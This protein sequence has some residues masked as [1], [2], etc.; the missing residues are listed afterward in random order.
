MKPSAKPLKTEELRR[1]NF[2]G[3]ATPLHV[4]VGSD[5]AR[6]AT[7]ML[8]C[9]ISSGEFPSGS[10]VQMESGMV[11]SSPELCFLQ[12]AGELSLA[13]LVALGYELCGGY[14]LDMENADGFRKDLPLTSI[15]S[16]SAYVAKAA[17]L[18]GRTNALKA[19]RFI[20]D[21][22]ASPMETILAIMLVLP[23]RL[24]GYGFPKPLHNYRIEVP[25]SVRKTTGKSNYYCD[26]YWPGRKVTA[27][28]DSDAFHTGPERIAKD[29]I[30]RN[31]L[32]SMGV[33]VV[34]VSRMQVFG[35]QKRRELAAV[36]SK[37][38][39]KR[40][41]FPVKGFANRCAELLEQLLP[42]QPAGG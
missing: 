10:F 17:R 38:L 4:V 1:E 3:L 33:T 41:Q 32:S 26:M 31:A 9:H 23:H 36:L 28:Y 21:G 34:T 5:N 40:L 29:A 14:R 16:L 30:R 11:V 8:Q 15:S 35:A 20:S 7:R 6:K 2:W 25:A 22:S 13:K 42:R 12:M 19:L 24:G 18:K 27:E 39:G 37:L